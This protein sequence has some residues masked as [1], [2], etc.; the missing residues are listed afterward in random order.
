MKIK[1]ILLIVCAMLCMMMFTACSTTDNTTGVGDDMTD[2]EVYAMAG[3]YLTYLQ[4]FTEEAAYEEMNDEKFIALSDISNIEEVK[5]FSIMKTAVAS[6]TGSLE[7][8]GTFEG[9]TGRELERDDESLTVTIDADYSVHQVKMQVVFDENM[10]LSSITA[11]PVLTVNEILMKALINTLL[12]MG[13]VFVV[14]IFISF[15][16]SGF[17]LI[18]KIQKKSEDKK[19]A[20]IEATRLVVNETVTEVVSDATE[21]IDDYELIAVISAAIAMAEGT[22]VDGFRVRSIKRAKNSSWKRA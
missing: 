1:K 21:E 15:I 19:K 14:L 7:D 11:D 2:D 13:T 4:S 6:Y 3:D 8:F 18:S 20:K 9:I 22:S 12:G 16:I 10:E 17:K 5:D